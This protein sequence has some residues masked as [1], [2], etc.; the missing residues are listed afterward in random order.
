M[1]DHAKEKIGDKIGRIYE[2]LSE[3]PVAIALGVLWLIG[4]VLVGACALVLYL[5]AHWAVCVLW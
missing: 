2:W 4:A 3:L 1:G 5:L